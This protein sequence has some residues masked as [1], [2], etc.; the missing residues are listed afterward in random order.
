MRN[1]SGYLP[2]AAYYAEEFELSTE[3]RG[4]C[5]II[6]PIHLLRDLVQ[7]LSAY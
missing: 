2:P 5:R 3:F 7:K 1:D 4:L 6:L